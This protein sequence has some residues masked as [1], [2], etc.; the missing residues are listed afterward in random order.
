MSLP[1]TPTSGKRP[2][3]LGLTEPDLAS[4]MKAMKAMNERL[5]A[6]EQKIDQFSK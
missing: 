6:M 2:A 4:M 5:A 3:P 1:K